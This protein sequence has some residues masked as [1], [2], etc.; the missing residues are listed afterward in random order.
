LLGSLL[1]VP[2]AQ[3]HPG[4]QHDGGLLA[5]IVHSFMSVGPAWLLLVIGIGYGLWAVYRRIT[6]AR[7]HARRR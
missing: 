6:Q 5:S 1:V 4:H 7:H 2:M 3:A